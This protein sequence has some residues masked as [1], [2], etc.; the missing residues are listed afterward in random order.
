MLGAGSVTTGTIDLGTGD[1]TLKFLGTATIKAADIVPGTGSNSLVF[2]GA[3]TLGYDFSG[4]ENTTKQGT[5]TFTL[6][7]LPTMRNLTINQGTLQVNSSYAM[8]GNSAFRTY[9]N[10][11][12][13][14]AGL[15]SV[16]GTA[17]LAGGLTV[18]KGPGYFYNGSIYNIITGN[19]IAGVF[20]S[21]MLPQSTPL[22]SFSHASESHRRSGY[23]PRQE[24]YN[25]CIQSC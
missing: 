13:G 22:L 20:S 23:N 16:N 4:F 5:G 6:A 2:D 17:S 11:N 21:V 18:T 1:D 8:A 7:S 9:V 3:G 10:G 24:L 15:L 12:N 19:S 14:G 25:L